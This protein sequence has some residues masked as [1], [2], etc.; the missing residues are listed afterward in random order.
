MN[1][2]ETFQLLE[3]EVAGR[4][5]TRPEIELF[6]K[7]PLLRCLKYHGYMV[8]Y[9]QLEKQDELYWLEDQEG[10]ARSLSS[11][12]RQSPIGVSYAPTQPVLSEYL[13]TSIESYYLTGEFQFEKGTGAHPIEFNM[14]GKKNFHI[15]E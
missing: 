1:I 9:D 14:E 8:S 6:V 12:M 13:V 11:E 10:L 2:E 5:L 4:R 7:N 3:K 15:S